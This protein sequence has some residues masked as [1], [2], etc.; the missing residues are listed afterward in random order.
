MKAL[1]LVPILFLSGCSNNNLF[2]GEVHATVGTHPVTVTD[3]YRFRV[4]PPRRTGKDAYEFTHAG[5]LP[6]P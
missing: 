5:M 6:S 3:C 4:D 2:L 1:A